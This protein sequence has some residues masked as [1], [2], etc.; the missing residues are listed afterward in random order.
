M[1]GAVVLALLVAAASSLA[2]QPAQVNVRDFGAKGDGVTD[3]T[4]AFQAALD[5]MR[6]SG[7]TVF[8]PA[9]TYLIK[10]HLTVPNSVT[11]EGVWKIP[12]CWR[13]GSGS[14]LLAVEGEGSEDGPAFITLGINSTIKGITIFYPNQKPDAIKPYP[15]CIAC[16]GGD[17]SSI[18]DCLLV[19]PYNG[20]DFGSRPSG[21]HYIRNL[22][23]QPLR[24]G[25]FVDKCYD[26]GRIENVHFWPFWTWDEKRGIREWLVENGEAFIFART[27]WEYV[28]NTFCF[29]YGVGYRFIQSKDGAANG[30]FLG[31]GADAANIALLVE[32][33]QPP[34]LLITN[35][36]F[37]SFQGK[38]PTEVVIK[39]SH[40]G[41]VQLSNCSFWGPAHQIAR[42]S[43]TG[44]V[45]FNACNFVYW[46]HFRKGVPAIETFGG[47]LIVNAC[48]FMA[49][50]KQVAVRGKTESAIVTANRM[51]GPLSVVNECGADVQVG[52]NVCKKPPQRPKEEQGAI[53]VDDMDGAPNVSFE[54]RWLLAPSDA[55]P[56]I[57]YYLGTHWAYKGTGD[58]KA[59]F[60]P[61]VPKSGRYA[62]YAWI[63]PDP[64]SDHAS[65]APVVISSADGRQTVR[66]DL[67]K[68]RGEWVKLGTFRFVKGRKGSVVFS[69]DADGNVLADAV[70]L[71][72]TD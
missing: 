49:A 32:Q 14:I 4:A 55:Q 11:L 37:V 1:Y 72:P 56:G 65:N 26:I 36:E 22:Y 38:D 28:F 40:S 67:R 23:G 31:I 48:N 70:K 62:V 2:G 68:R 10:S 60:T 44:T 39:D 9:G 30:N 5:S 3:D 42:I 17:N 71:V 63:G 66:I 6:E 54:G 12:V 61:N 13:A 43:G 45:I 58:A 53:V 35:G 47:N 52:L 20:V 46:D 18:I 7:G 64:M 25:I 69:N 16:A 34:G 41:V 27:D 19:N 15:W 21:R 24:R 50:A 8:V 57:G 59:V 51:A 29:G 33:T